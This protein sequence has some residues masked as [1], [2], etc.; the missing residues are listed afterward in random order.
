MFNSVKKYIDCSVPIHEERKISIFE[1]FEGIP[2]Q[3]DVKLEKTAI[4]RES[5][6]S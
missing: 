3:L 6:L 1:I 4:T 2:A 5:N